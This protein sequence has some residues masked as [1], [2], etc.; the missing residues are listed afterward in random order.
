MYDIIKHNC[1]H[2]AITCSSPS[3]PTGVVI[4]HVQLGYTQGQESDYGHSSS[5]E[6][7]YGTRLTL[8]CVSI[9][10]SVRGQ[11]HLTCGVE[12]QWDHPPPT[13]EGE[14]YGCGFMWA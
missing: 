3:L 14:S 6:Y 5:S 13:C 2:T 1:T 10:H 11:R 7:L 12:G 8:A 4:A 9:F